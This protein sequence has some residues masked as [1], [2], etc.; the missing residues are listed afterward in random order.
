MEKALV[1]HF[2][3]LVN[4]LSQLNTYNWDEKFKERD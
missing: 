3:W 4:R 1:N 2:T